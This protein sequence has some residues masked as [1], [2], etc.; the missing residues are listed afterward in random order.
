MA[1]IILQVITDL[2]HA[3]C[4]AIPAD[5]SAADAN[6]AARARSTLSTAECWVVLGVLAPLARAGGFT[7]G[8][9]VHALKETAALAVGVSPGAQGGGGFLHIQAACKELEVV[10]DGLVVLERMAASSQGQEKDGG[11]EPHVA[12]LSVVDQ[13][14][15]I[16]YTGLPEAAPPSCDVLV[17]QDPVLRLLRECGQ[18]TQ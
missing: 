1:N 11:V 10:H 13:R 5:T 6:S 15:T 12:L 17:G 8:T 14:S 16:G 3:L 18:V 9:V 7:L 4:K 2:V